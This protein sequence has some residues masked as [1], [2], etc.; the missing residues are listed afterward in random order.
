[1][2]IISPYRQPG[3]VS[4]EGQKH[5]ADWL[6]EWL[7]NKGQYVVLDCGCSED[8]KWRGLTILVKYGGPLG[9]RRVVFC[10][11]CNQFSLVKKSATFYEYVGGKKPPPIPEDPPY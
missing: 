11:R 5:R 10:E 2:R 3:R 4:S 1:M 8:L 9:K 6:T 7:A